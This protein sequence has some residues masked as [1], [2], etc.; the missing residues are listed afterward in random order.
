MKKKGFFLLILFF[1]FLVSTGVYAEQKFEI[2]AIKTENKVFPGSEITFLLNVKNVQI[3][4]DIVKVSPDPF[5]AYPFSDFINSMSIKP[6][7]LAIPSS[8]EGIFEVKIKYA[9]VLKGERAYTANVIVK[10]LLNDEIRENF[11]LTSFIMS[12]GQIVNLRTDLPSTITPGRETEFEVIFKN[13]LNEDLGDMDF[14][15]I[16][17][18]FT[19]E[20]KLTLRKNEEIGKK[21]SI[22]MPPETPAGYYS[23]FLRL[24]KDGSL[25]GETE[26]VFNV[27][28]SKDLQE[29]ITRESGFLSKKVILTKTN[30][31]NVPAEKIIKYPIG[32]FQKLF[33]ETSLKADYVIEGSERYLVWNLVISP[34]KEES[35]VIE[36]NYNSL[37]F[38][39]FAL[40]VLVGVIY[41][42]KVRSLR[43]TK[44]V[45]FLKEGPNKKPQYKVLLSIQNYSTKSIQDLK[46]IDLLPSLIKHYSDFGT[47]EPSHI[48]QGSKG[49]RF[50]WD[51]QKLHRGEERILTYKI[52]P[53]MNLFGHLRL[54][55]ASLQFSKNGRLVIRSSNI[56]KFSIPSSMSKAEDKK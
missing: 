37:F 46:I 21:F 25:K 31:G 49:L 30:N 36:T 27:E 3:R 29:K 41:Y 32:P 35:I 52:E 22:L 56:A 26:V 14:F 43:I 16:S 23:L 53:Q 7:Q 24:N 8:G 10:S 39:F 54:P 13:N 51:I 28:L 19:Q 48:Q 2:S 5:S 1:L 42:T 44:K 6:S 38:T 4:D 20:H 15:I 34:G 17:N 55:P 11:P 47:L 50:V 40:I 18:Y 33:T 45:V 12:A 9:E